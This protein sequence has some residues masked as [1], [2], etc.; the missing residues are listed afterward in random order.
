MEKW[1]KFGERSLDCSMTRIMGILN[2]TPDS[3]SDGGSHA[4]ADAAVE[5]AMRMRSEGAAIIDVGGES[6]RP[7]APEIAVA[8]EIDR[9]AP[10]IRR[11]R[12]K[13]P[14]C[15][16]SID[17]RKSEVAAAAMDAG[18]DI[19]NDVSGLSYSPGMAGVAAQSGAGLVIMHMRGT[20]A[21]MQ[22]V[23]N[24]T[25]RNLLEEVREFLEQASR[26]A[27]AAGVD[28]D[29]IVWDPGIGLP[30]NLPQNL[31]LVNRIGELAKAGFPLLAGPSRK[32]FIGAILDQPN[33]A[34]RL[35]GTDGANAWLAMQGVEIV[36]VH[37]VAEMGEML[38]VLEACRTAKW[39]RE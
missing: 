8:E 11:L 19:I 29:K 5:H 9:V 32:S 26:Q 36:R 2:V 31:E 18:A 27:I 13:A 30:K 17:T 14:E 37:D 1:L 7:G 10:V 12:K 33:P 25:Y 3:F 34:R 35:W 21:D 16:I 24:L 39:E 15:I 28:K 4:T 23:E 22:S 6:T 38:R 20:P